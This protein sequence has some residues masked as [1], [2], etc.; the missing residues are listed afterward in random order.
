MTNFLSVAPRVFP[1]TDYRTW[2]LFVI[3]G[4][5]LHLLFVCLSGDLTRN[6]FFVDSRM[7]SRV[8]LFF[9]VCRFFNRRDRRLN[10]KANLHVSSE[11]PRTA[12][13][14]SFTAEGCALF[15]SALGFPHFAWRYT[16]TFLFSHHRRY[17]LTLA[18][19][20]RGEMILNRWPLKTIP[21]WLRRASFAPDHV[22]ISVFWLET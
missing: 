21:Q 17:S 2:N 10:L 6:Y 13:E 1:R 16:I 9:C 22:M 11:P 15:Q 14:N 8:V 3:A 19:V 5:W 18:R 7:C 12:S 20:C 4:L